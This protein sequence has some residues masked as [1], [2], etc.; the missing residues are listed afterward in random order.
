MQLGAYAEGGSAP[1]AL[2]EASV[3]DGSRFFYLV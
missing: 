3:I 2:S 1:G